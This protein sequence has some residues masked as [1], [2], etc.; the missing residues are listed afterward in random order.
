MLFAQFTALRT[1]RQFGCAF[2][3]RKDIARFLQKNAA[4]FGQ[5]DAAVGARQQAHPRFLPIAGFAG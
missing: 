3:A 1:L 2:D 4:W 5:R